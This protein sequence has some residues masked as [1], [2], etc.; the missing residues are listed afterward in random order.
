MVFYDIT[1]LIE[2]HLRHQ[3]RIPGSVVKQQTSLDIASLVFAIAGSICL[4]MLSI[5]DAFE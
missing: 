4:L 1:V 2:R 5:F 3:R